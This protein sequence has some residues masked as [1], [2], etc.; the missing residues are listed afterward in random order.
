MIAMLAKFLN[1]SHPCN[2]IKY[3]SKVIAIIFPICNERVDLLVMNGFQL[4]AY[5]SVIDFRVF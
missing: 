1:N 2:E 3:K 5:V 4:H